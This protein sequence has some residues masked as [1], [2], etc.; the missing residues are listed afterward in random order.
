MTD[1]EI[2]TMLA[3]VERLR[4]ALVEAADDLE[5]WGAY[6][7]EYFREKWDLAGD[8]ARIRLAAVAP[9]EPTS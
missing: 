4:A 5:S 3:E 2:Q 7:G 1:D 9:K 6:A 8:V